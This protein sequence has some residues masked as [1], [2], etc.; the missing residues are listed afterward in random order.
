MVR[1]GDLLTGREDCPVAQYM[2]TLYDLWGSDTVHGDKIA[3]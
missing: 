1:T 3:Y 2:D